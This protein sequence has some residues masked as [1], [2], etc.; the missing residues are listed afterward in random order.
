MFQHV[1]LRYTIKRDKH[2][3]RRAEENEHEHELIEHDEVFKSSF[4]FSIA[5]LVYRQRGHLGRKWVHHDE[6]LRKMTIT[7]TIL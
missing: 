2:A 6:F 7:T 1:N 5:K 3:Q 4:E